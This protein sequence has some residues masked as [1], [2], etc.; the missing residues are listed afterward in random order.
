MKIHSIVALIIFS[1]A[2]LT[3]TAQDIFVLESEKFD[4]N[5]VNITPTK[6]P[7]GYLSLVIRYQRNNWDDPK[8]LP[9]SSLNKDFNYRYI[10]DE[11]NVYAT[12]MD[13]DL[14]V[15][16]QEKLKF[17]DAHDLNIYGLFSYDG[18]STLYYSKRK[19]F[20]DEVSICAMN[21]DVG[22]LRKCRARVI[23][24]IKS[25][26][27]VPATRMIVSPD[28]TKLAFIS[29]KFFNDDDER[30]LDVALFNIE[31]TPM[32]SDK[33]YLGDKTEKLTIGDIALDNIGNIYV[34][35][36]L[37][38][39][40]SN[41]RSKK[42][43]NGDRIPAYK[44]KIVTYGIDETEATLT[45]DHENYFLR[46]CDLIYNAE[47]GA[48]QAL[49]TYSIKDGGNL[50]GVYMSTIDAKAYDRVSTTFHK[51]DDRLID[52]IDEDGFGQ[53]KDKDPGVEIRDVEVNIII[54]DDG[55]IAY[56]MQPYKYNEV[57]SN[58]GVNLRNTVIDAGY[59]AYS[60]IVA[61]IDDDA[62]F[63]RIP[64]LTSS[65]S[66]YGEL[67]AKSIYDNNNVYIVY[68]DTH[69]NLERDINKRPKTLNPTRASLILA[70]IDAEGNFERSFLKNR[71][72]E[73]NFSMSLN[74]LHHI[75][76]KNLFYSFYS[77][78][79]FSGTDRQV[80]IISF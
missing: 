5:M 35:Y 49:G 36:K 1:L 15:I 52:L 4:D 12:I 23:H 2:S 80:G 38:D 42:N 43:K 16:K 71:D 17:K 68:M 78:G 48:I 20:S 55:G 59:N 46:R 11:D 62:V 73:G 24:T 72:E 54:K 13:E 26:K 31:G 69:K 39:R 75:N 3:M 56:I 33:V 50:T 67:M 66:P 19:N 41:N 37:Y 65:E 64:R 28:S 25:R 74:D 32:W 40:Y 8:M 22:K 29:E 10:S 45:I 44:T 51:F 63:T 47:R 61:Q 57:I 79:F 53:T 14:N 9:I 70:N 76:N 58:N 7:G 27:G 21:I 18:K 34:S 60:M 30:K 77:G 6:I